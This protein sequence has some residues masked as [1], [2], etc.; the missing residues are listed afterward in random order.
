MPRLDWADPH[1]GCSVWKPVRVGSVEALS[2]HR[3]ED[4]QAAVSRVL[5]RSR[6][7]DTLIRKAAAGLAVVC[8]E[9]LRERTGGV[10]GRRVV[11]LVGTGNNGADALVA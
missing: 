7:H 6:S 9:V 11:L 10:N 2:A 8:A 3:S 5:A 1:S 4:V